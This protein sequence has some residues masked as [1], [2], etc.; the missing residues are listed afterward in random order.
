MNSLL[1][2]FRISYLIL[3]YTN[4]ITRAQPDFQGNEQKIDRHKD[5][6][7]RTQPRVFVKEDNQYLHVISPHAA[8]PN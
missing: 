7:D 5:S 8:N 2:E 3:K 6:E 1:R 4:R